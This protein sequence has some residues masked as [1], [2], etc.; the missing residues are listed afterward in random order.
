MYPSCCFVLKSS[1]KGVFRNSVRT[2]INSFFWIDQSS[3]W[4]YEMIA[5]LFSFAP[6]S[7]GIK[8]C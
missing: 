7:S 6:D 3:Y 8:S 4:K 5:E 2:K 1:K